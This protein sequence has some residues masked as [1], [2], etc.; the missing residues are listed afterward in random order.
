MLGI[1]RP[2]VREAMNQLI[3]EGLLVQ[4]PTRVSASLSQPA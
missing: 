3:S 2:T 1:S 4:G